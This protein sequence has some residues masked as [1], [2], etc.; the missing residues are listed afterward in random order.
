MPKQRLS[1]DVSKT[2]TFTKSSLV[3]SSER[4]KLLIQSQ[5]FWICRSILI[6]ACR[7]GLATT[8][9]SMRNSLLHPRLWKNNFHVLTHHI[10]HSILCDAPFR[11]KSAQTDKFSLINS[12]SLLQPLSG[13]EDS[14][15][16]HLRLWKFISTALPSET[17]EGNVLFVGHAATTIACSS[18]RSILSDF[19]SFKISI[20]CFALLFLRFQ[21]G[22]QLEFCRGH[23]TTFSQRWALKNPCECWLLQFNSNGLSSTSWIKPKVAL[24]H[25][26]FRRA[27]SRG[28]R[29]VGQRKIFKLVVLRG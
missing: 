11:L 24:A 15:K 22:L 17:L 3:P 5:N 23:R 20:I 27:S 6:M 26:W 10:N 13:F 14:I 2:K 21:S 1:R 28:S 4:S 29:S 19:I 7:N 12:L 8:C 18:T 25:A 16:V 9:W